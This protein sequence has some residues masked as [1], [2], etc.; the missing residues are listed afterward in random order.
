MKTIALLCLVGAFAAGAFA[1][2]TLKIMSW[3]LLNYVDDSRD[4][5]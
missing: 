3:N 2:D 1:Q 5:Y 4:H